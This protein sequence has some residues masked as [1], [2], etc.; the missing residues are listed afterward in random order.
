MS[1][2]AIDVEGLGKRYTLSHLRAPF[3]TIRERLRLLP[4]VLARR[5]SGWRR[6]HTGLREEAFWAVRDLSFQV[7]PGERLGII[8]RNGAGKSTLLKL[9]SRITDPTEGRIAIQGRVASLLEIGTGFHPDLT[10]RENIF[11]NGAVLGMPRKEVRNKFDEIV[12]FAEVERFLDT[13][14]KRYSSGMYVRLAFAVAAHLTPE[15]LIV[16]EVLAVGDS[17][18][19]KKCL[20]TMQDMSQSGGRTILFVSHNM[21]AVQ[22]LCTRAML[23]SR[24]RLAGFG[25]VEDMVDLY[26]RRS[27]SS[28][29]GEVDIAGDTFALCSVAVSAPDLSP[30]ATFKR[31]AIEIVFRPLLDVADAGATILFEDLNGAPIFG[32]DSMDFVDNV[33][34]KKGAP[35]KVRFEIDS[36][37]LNPGPFGLRLELK[38]E[39]QHLYWEV[40][41]LF[42]VH[43][44][45]TLVYGPRRPT[46]QV[47]GCAASAARATVAAL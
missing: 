23:L 42:E 14:V 25:N 46:R 47:H 3:P 5:M 30:L 26:A 37:P 13:P 44:E 35:V 4:Q 27:D 24:G 40:P 39:S 2:A 15:I 8:G 22:S 45:D 38:S 12:A 16:D 28:L 19:Q 10:G 21:A 1:P 18:F 20:G 11:V 33:R 32:L 7:Q 41:K 31:A 6:P 36:L 34:A 29:L 17:Q 43:V 9:L